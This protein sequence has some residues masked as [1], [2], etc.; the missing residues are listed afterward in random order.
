MS[1]PSAPGIQNFAPPIPS[2][3]ARVLRGQGPR[4]ESHCL[5]MQK[6]EESP[7]TPVLMSWC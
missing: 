5:R 2:S 4:S 3:L 7:G 1:P 6:P